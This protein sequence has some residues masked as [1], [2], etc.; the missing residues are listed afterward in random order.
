MPA[1]FKFY[2]NKASEKSVVIMMTS[3]TNATIQVSAPVL[4]S[5]DDTNIIGTMFTVKTWN[6]DAYGNEWVT[7]ENFFQFFDN[8]GLPTNSTLQL[9]FTFFNQ[10][11][12]VENVTEKFLMV[13]RRS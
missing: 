2:L 10:T 4:G 7:F 5:E 6:K 12:G 11:T 3:D 13:K 8:S 9:S 1:N